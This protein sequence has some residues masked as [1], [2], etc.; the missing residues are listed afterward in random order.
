MP[1]AQVVAVLRNVSHVDPDVPE[2]DRKR[3]GRGREQLRSHG[4]SARRRP[5]GEPSGRQKAHGRITGAT[6]MRIAAADQ[7][8][9]WRLS[10]PT[11]KPGMGIPA[12][13]IPALMTV[14]CHVEGEQ[15]CRRDQACPG[16]AR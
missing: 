3:Q 10:S 5:R 11:R 14:E 1:G 13:A 2:V 15:G 9:A 12:G 16:R 4:K 7:S 8:S 6:H